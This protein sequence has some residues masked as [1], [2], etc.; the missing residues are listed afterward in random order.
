MSPRPLPAWLAKVEPGLDAFE[1]LEHC[2]RETMRMLQ[3]L[4]MLVTR[5]DELGIDAQ[6]RRMARAADHYFSE[7]L[8]QHHVDEESHVFPALAACGD[9]ET[10]QALARLKQ[11][12]AWLRAD[13]HVLSP[14]VRALGGGQSWVD[15]DA[16]R[17]GIEVFGTLARDHI[18][19][20]ESLIYPQARSRMLEAS[21]REM[22]REMAS[23]R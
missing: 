17:D 18:A 5:V 21:R 10:V 7:D 3:E 13:W 8:R 6:A 11:D 16:L 12:H 9:A 23:R 1:P 2:H 15:L 4:Q 19:L 22:R 20:E 14:L